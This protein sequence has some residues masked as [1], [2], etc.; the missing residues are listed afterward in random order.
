M[1]LSTG[2][3]LMLLFTI[4]QAADCCAVQNASASSRHQ[5]PQELCTER[6]A[7]ELNQVLGMAFYTCAHGSRQT[8]STGENTALIMDRFKSVH[9]P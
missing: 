9:W 1:T 2:S 8:L 6:T 5:L 4:T 7:E 3:A